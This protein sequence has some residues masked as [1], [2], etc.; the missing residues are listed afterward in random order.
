M[1]YICRAFFIFFLLAFSTEVFSQ[2]EG[3]GYGKR[4][5]IDASEV[6]GA[7]PLTDFPVMIR[8]MGATADLDLRSVGNGGHVEDATGY[9]IIFGADQAGATLLDHQIESYNPATGEYVAWVRI[10]TLSNTVNTDIYM[11]YGNCSVSA[12]PSVTSVWNSDFDAVYFLNDDFSDATGGTAGTNTGSTDTSPALIADGQNFGKNDY[13]QIPSASIST[14]SGTVSIWAR[15]PDFLGN[16]KYL[17]GHTSNPNGFADRIQLY[18]DDNAGGLDLGLGNNHS[19]EQGI[20]TLAVDVWNYVALTWNG[21]TCSVYV[22]GQLEHTEAY[23]GLGTLESYL[24]IGN[25]GRANAARNEGW[26]GDLDHARLSNEVFSASWIETE[27]NN[28]RENATFYSTSGE[29]NASRTF[30]S[31]ASGAWESNSSWSFTPD[32]SSGAVGAGVFPKRTDN[33]VIQNGHTITIDNVD[34]NG[35]CSQSPANLARANVGAFTGSTDQMFYH[36][37]DIVVA[38]GGTLTSSEEVMVEGYTL[39]ENG[40]TLTVTED[41]VNLGYFELAATA[42]FTNTDDLILSGNSVT[43]IDNTSFG[44]DD[45]YIDWTDATLCGS[46]IVNLGNGGADPTIQFFNGGS[47]DQVCADFS[48]TCSSNCGAF[49][50]T[51]TGSFIT[52]NAGPG[53]VGNQ[54]N[55]QL[56]LRAN[57]LSLSDGVAVTSWPDVSGN[58]LTAVSSGVGTEEPTFNAN[59]VNTSLPSVSFDGGDFLNLGTPAGLNLIPGTDSWSF[60]IVYNVAGATP[61][62]TFF[63]KATSTGGTRQYQYTIDDDTGTSRFSSFIGGNLAVG[64]VVA[65]NDWFVSS[66]TN[67]TATRDSWTNEGADFVGVGIGTGQVP[68]AE[69]LIGA[70]RDAGPTTGSGFHLTGDIAEIA[71]YDGEVNT[72]Q[73]IIIDN[74]LSAKYDIDISAS[75]NDVYTMDDPGNGD[76][77]FEVAGIGRA[78]DGSVHTDARGSGILRVWNPSDLDDGEF[79]F[80]GHDNASISST[81]KAVGTD[82]DG[83][84]IEEKLSRNWIVAKTGDVGTVSISFD[85]SGVGG[86]P[87][88]SNLRLLVDRDGDFSTND[89][90]PLAGTV[91]NKIAVFSGVSLQDGDRF[92]L[93]NTDVSVPLPVELLS[94]S[95]TAANSQVTLEWATGSELNNDFFSV[96]SSIDAQIWQE[97]LQVKGVGTTSEKQTY[98]AVDHQPYPGKS[99]YRLKQTDFDGTISYSDVEK[100]DFTLSSD[101]TIYPNPSGNR[102][103]LRGSNSFNPSH[104]KIYNTAGQEIN[105][106]IT[107]A[108]GELMIDLVSYPS[109]VYILHFPINGSLQSFRLVKL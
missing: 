41:I 8:F 19:L 82:V 7:S 58:G 66:H 5:T 43:I 62:G 44:A 104:V 98:R 61:Q 85:F 37:G 89:V 79:M 73:R 69:V 106:K 67:N 10:P 27:Y 38:N 24:D 42:N 49:P 29:F 16:E 71:M 94:F 21:T 46:G 88:G 64:S 22:N 81:T 17:F 109:G 103:K 36:T 47:L 39:V 11:F 70:R 30:Y 14:T 63:S 105:P 25:D 51:P 52:G 76:Y 23:G 78:A 57:D 59:A 45:I 102:F 74:Y 56:W 92:S 96:E 2:T 72:A 6:M 50:V 101:L 55:N 53:G 26:N 31:F 77:D 32:G 4:I 48:F 1:S 80:W 28:Q 93:G 35:G 99:F 100:V 95:A 12:D 75:G 97:I 33:A 13:V 91:S 108:S 68:T 83:T 86:S 3:F 15:T 87:L 60:F 34:D 18:S 54:N 65:T 40:G 107:V 84:V 9:D 90:T 20:V